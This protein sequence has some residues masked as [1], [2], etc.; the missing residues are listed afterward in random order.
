MMRSWTHVSAPSGGKVGVWTNKT[1][2]R[3][4]CDSR[5]GVASLGSGTAE[6]GRWRAAGVD[7]RSLSSFPPRGPRSCLLSRQGA[8]WGFQ[9]A[10]EYKAQLVAMRR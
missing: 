5:R 1:P 4:A 6:I 7:P 2:V 8:D 9:V 3:T 10:S